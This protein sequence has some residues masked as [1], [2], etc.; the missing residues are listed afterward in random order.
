VRQFD[1]DENLAP[2][3]IESFGRWSRLSSFISSDLI[4]SLSPVGGNISIMAEAEDPDLLNPK[5]EAEKKLVQQL[6]EGKAK[7]M[8][9]RALAHDEAE[10]SNIE[11]VDEQASTS[12]NMS[13]N[14]LI[15]DSEDADEW[16]RKASGRCFYTHL[17]RL[18]KRTSMT[19]SELTAMN[20]DKTGVLVKAVE[21]RYN[22]NMNAI[23]G[24]LQ[25]AFIA[26]VYCQSVDGFLQVGMEGFQIVCGESS[27]RILPVW[28]SVEKALECYLGIP[29]GVNVC[30]VCM[31]QQLLRHC[32]TSYV[33][34]LALNLRTDIT[35][36]SALK[37]F[38]LQWKS[39]LILLLS[40]EEAALHSHQVIYVKLLQVLDAQI[41]STLPNRSEANPK[42]ESGPLEASLIEELLPDSFLRKMFGFFLQMLQ[43]SVLEPPSARPITS[44]PFHLKC[45]LQTRRMTVKSLKPCIMKFRGLSKHCVAD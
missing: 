24:E 19:A 18:V 36:Y 8:D 9:R 38:P 20:L 23:L 2:Y 28:R 42:E 17:P 41:T 27:S 43:V 26:F 21:K 6:Q 29:S 37:L 4:A 31:C 16:R 39:L 30:V 34:Q 10:A 40:C 22:G 5:T 12:E 15:N 11:K 32:S 13:R 7:M 35:M 25:F 1:F 3:D 44:F 14:V 33:F 45:F